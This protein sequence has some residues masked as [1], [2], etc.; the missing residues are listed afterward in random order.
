MA[1]P[2]R[3]LVVGKDDCDLSLA[4]MLR[5]CGWDCLEFAPDD[6]LPEELGEAARPDV[7]VPIF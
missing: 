1:Q 2:A 3:V 7:V 4:R 5:L 6:E